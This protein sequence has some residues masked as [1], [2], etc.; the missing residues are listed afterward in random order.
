MTNYTL[1]NIQ[2]LA[3]AIAGKNWD[4]PDSEQHH[5]LIAYGTITWVGQDRTETEIAMLRVSEFGVLK[6]VTERAPWERG[7]IDAS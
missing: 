7:A 3:M 1:S 4:Q 6:P 5:V 2:P